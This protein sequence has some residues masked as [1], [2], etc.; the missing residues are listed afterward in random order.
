MNLG[1][2]KTRLSEKSEDWEA[3]D[4]NRIQIEYM[5]AENI[6]NQQIENISDYDKAKVFSLKDTV[7]IIF[8]ILYSNIIRFWLIILKFHSILISIIR[9]VVL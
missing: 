2:H 6:N 1:D 4:S 9:Y 3:V 5:S 8:Y 7:S